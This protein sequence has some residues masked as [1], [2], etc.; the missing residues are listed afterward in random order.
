[1]DD[2]ISHYTGERLTEADDL[3][4]PIIDGYLWPNDL[5]MILGNEKAGK[6]ILALQMAANLSSGTKFLDKYPC[7]KMPVA[8]LQTEGKKDETAYRIK[9][10]MEA[11]EFD[12]YNFHRLYKRFLP[13]DIPEYMTMLDNMIGSLEPKP[14]VLFDD[15]LYT[16]MMGDLN[17][18][19]DVRRFL[20]N[21]S[22]LLEKYSL[23][24]PIVHHAKRDQFFEGEKLELG[25][26]SSYGSVFLRA[27][28]DHIIFLEMQ[29]DKTRV[30][31]C[32]TQR[33]GKVASKEEL[34]LIQP[35]PLCFEIKGEYKAYEEITLAQLK[36]EPLT[37]SQIID[38]TGLSHSSVFQAARHL[39]R[40]KKITEIGSTNGQY[41]EKIYQAITEK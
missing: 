37:R 28:V 15:A 24:S 2:T 26:K 41:S 40:D 4:D 14:K 13:I 12:S 34:I 17:S 21:Y 23:T 27:N 16:T 38:R 22:I 20:F 18:N 7:Q 6:S 5:V 30:L 9:N 3:P 19:Q 31:T 36:K 11:I 29:R 10:M 1:M 25:D 32:D 33:S 8:Y 35:V 39:L